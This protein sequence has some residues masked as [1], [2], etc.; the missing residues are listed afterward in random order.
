MLLLV[1]LAI[2]FFITGGT[3]GANII[4]AFGLVIYAWWG[5]S[6]LITLIAIVIIL[7]MTA[8]GADVKGI[9]TKAG[10]LIGGSVGTL[11][12]IVLCFYTYA[13]LWLSYYIVENTSPVATNWETIGGDAQNGIIAYLAIT[14]LFIIR[15]KFSSK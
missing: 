7:G 6:I 12:A 4:G 5:L 8:L 14:I 2:G 1:L 15:A 10:A 3:F 11:L 9:S 13:M